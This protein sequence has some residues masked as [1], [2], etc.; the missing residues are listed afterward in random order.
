MDIS[1]FPKHIQ[2][3]LQN[4]ERVRL[5]HWQAT[6]MLNAIRQEMVDTEIEAV[7]YLKEWLLENPDMFDD[8][9]LELAPLNVILDNIIFPFN[10]PECTKSPFGCCVYSNYTGNTFCIFCRN[11]G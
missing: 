9:I 4:A 2:V 11:Q 8:Y 7:S 3:A 1:K 6:T 10:G 5:V